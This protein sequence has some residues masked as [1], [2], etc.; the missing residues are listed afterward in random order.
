MGVTPGGLGVATPQNLRWGLQY[1]SNPQNFIRTPPYHHGNLPL[2]DT[3]NYS[4]FGLAEF[5][6]ANELKICRIRPSSLRLSSNV[7]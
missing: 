4:S 5:F 2:F 6:S 3:E 1:I 7:C